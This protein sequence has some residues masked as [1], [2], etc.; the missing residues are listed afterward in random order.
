[1]EKKLL[2]Y[3]L[4]LTLIVVA[5]FVF[6][7]KKGYSEHSGVRE[8]LFKTTDQALKNAE[9]KNAALYSPDR[10]KDAL[11]YYKDAEIAYENNESIKS[12]QRKLDKASENF[13]KA[14]DISDKAAVF[15]RSAKS[16]RD[17]AEK[18]EAVK[19]LENWKKA[20]ESFQEAIRLLQDGNSNEAKGIANEAVTLY[21]IAKLETNKLD[22]P[23]TR[24][25]TMAYVVG[26]CGVAADIAKKGSDTFSK[27][28]KAGLQLLIK[29]QKLCPD[30]SAFQYN[31]GA[32]WMV[33]GKPDSAVTWFESAVKLSP[34][35][36]SFRNALASA[37][38][39]CGKAPEALGHAKKAVELDTAQA[40]YAETLC[41]AYAASGDLGS[42][43]VSA[44]K[45][46]QTF[47]DHAGIKKAFAEILDAYLADGLNKIKSGVGEEK[48]FA[49][50]KAAA[51]EPS[52]ARAYCL[53]LASR[54]KTD[55][56]LS[57]A[58]DAES[59]LNGNPS[60]KGLFAEIL[61]GRIRQIYQAFSKGKSQAALSDAKQLADAYP[62]SEAKPAYDKLF[63]AFINDA[64]T[65]DVPEP[66]VAAQKTTS[67]GTTSS[68]DA[69]LGTLW[70]T[71]GENAEPE[72]LTVDVDTTIP[73]G[74]IS[75]PDAVAVVIG[76][77][78]YKKTGNGVPDVDY[79]ER[80]AAVMKK[81]LVRTMGFN[82]KN[83]IFKTDATSG[84]LRN[85]F[86]SADNLKGQLHNYC[87]NESEVFIYYSGHGAPGDDGK[88][89]YL[90]PVD[91]SMD[92]IKNT[93]YSLD[94]FYKSVGNLPSKSVTVV[95]DACFSG[96][97][98]GGQL[99]TNVSPALVKNIQPVRAVK[100]CVIFSA[101]DK[102]QVSVWNPEKR[103]GLFTYY[104]L[105]G[106]SGEANKGK[107]K[108]ITAGEMRDY[109]GGEVTYMAQRI[110]NRVQTPMMTGDDKVVLTR[111]K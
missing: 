29:A 84:D 97:S 65:I 40:E 59:R 24:K 51:S 68:S 109:L 57:T 50:L 48:G 36:A 64:A 90:V 85:I 6:N 16:A 93:G 47:P 108:E 41:R 19:G 8:A 12:I 70:K 45:A 72:N 86:G 20:E 76:N 17:D 33:Y 15:F 27:D 61:S 49:M 71:P 11:E 87:R 22:K 83:I 99:F 23:E 53:A 74:K 25:E 105:K 39:E 21:T 32:A 100:N 91:A 104:F 38:L 67:G 88:S 79:A 30:D 92:Y 56:A 7:P 95:L 55:M 10:Y 54:G 96:G 58:K 2:R 3:I 73:E 82:E 13:D 37:L 80:D 52:G 103:H 28:K 69:I 107:N 1:M 42:A 110:A 89:A 66:V 18:I 63:N 4:S 5:I 14:A 78:H 26:P 34:L 60:V 35:S 75:R 98:G 94:L 106:L 9:F 62:A 101:A 81:Y 31:L 46:G 43:F 102:D 111:L 44:R 77:T